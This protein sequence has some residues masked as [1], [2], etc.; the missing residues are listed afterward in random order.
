MSSSLC[1]RWLRWASAVR[2][3]SL[4][5]WEYI[6]SWS[7]PQVSCTPACANTHTHTQKHHTFTAR[8]HMTQRDIYNIHNYKRWAY[9][10]LFIL[11][12]IKNLLHKIRYLA[13]L[14]CMMFC[15]DILCYQNIKLSSKT[16]QIMML[17]PWALLHVWPPTF[18]QYINIY[19]VF[20]PLLF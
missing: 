13:L 3:R 17:Q 4:R 2:R 5:S 1:C 18:I 15:V 6:N 19:S 14:K 10:I 12:P 7:R 8:F 11:M 9:M 16:T 20:G